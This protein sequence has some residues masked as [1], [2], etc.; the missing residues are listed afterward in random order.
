MCFSTQYV[1]TR[2]QKEKKYIFLKH[3]AFSALFTD[4]CLKKYFSKRYN[5]AKLKISSL[6]WTFQ[7]NKQKNKIKR[8]SFK[9]KLKLRNVLSTSIHYP[10]YWS[11]PSS[12]SIIIK[13]LDISTVKLNLTYLHI[14]A[15]TI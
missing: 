1:A 4:N 10:C 14:N 12:L 13:K 6:A 8:N 5:K 2:L 9:T 15:L 3:L 11:N 7:C